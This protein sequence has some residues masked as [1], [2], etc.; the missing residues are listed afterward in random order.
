MEAPIGRHL[1]WVARITQKAFND[2]LEGAGGS[3]P[4]WLILLSLER[5]DYATQLELA[6]AVGI[7]GPTLTHHLDSME[8]QGLVSRVRD[9]N[10]RR[11]I[12]V[13]LTPAGE[14]LFLSLREAALGFDR[15]LRKRVSPEELA[16]TRSV[17]TRFAENVR[18]ER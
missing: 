18:D 16:V 14:K 17:L 6:R 8:R 11:A 15:K 9:L 12:R 1:H 10:N 13:K 4:T 5:E 2:A 3:L 7:E